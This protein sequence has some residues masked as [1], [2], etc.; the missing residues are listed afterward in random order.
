MRAPAFTAAAIVTLAL[1]IGANTALFTLLDAIALRPL[2]VERPAQLVQLTY[3]IPTG[4]PN[5]AFSYPEFERA[6]QSR[7]FS[8]VF[9]GTTVG[10]V[11]L[12]ARGVA[13][14]A[15]AQA[16]SPNF[17][18]FLGLHVPALEGSVA[19]LSDHY[20]RSRFAADPS[21]VGARVTVNQVPLT[22]IG[23]APPNFNGMY[24]G[25]TADVWI[26]LRA[27]DQLNPDPLR[28]TGPDRAWIHIVGRLRDG[29]TLAA[30]QQELAPLHR[31]N[32]RILLRSVETGAPGA[33]Q[34]TYR[35][36]LQLLLAIAGVVLLA[37]CANIANLQLARV[38]ARRREIAV[39]MALGASRWRIARQLLGESLILAVAGGALAI[40]LARFGAAALADSIDVSPDWRVFAFTAVLSVAAGAVF[41]IAPAWGATR[42][43][44][45]QR[46]RLG[47]ALVVVQVTLSV[48]LVAG[49][50]LFV[51][52]L[53][54]LWRV[55]V[56]YDRDNVLLFSVDTKLAGYPHVRSLDVY[57]QV[58]DR[59]RAVPGVQSAAASMVRPAD[60]YFS[61]VD[62]LNEL[63]GRQQREPIRVGWN[64][65]TPGYFETISTP[66]LKGRDFDDRDREGAPKVAIVS[67]SLAARAFP[68]QDPIGHRVG[69]WTVVGVVRD[70]RYSGP[71]DEASPMLYYPLA[72]NNPAFAF[73]SFELRGAPALDDVR[74]AVQQV[75]PTLP[76][77]RVRTLRAQFEMA[78]ESER[79]VATVSTAFGALA[80]VLSCVGLYGLMAYAVARRT[81][82]IGV[83]MALGARRGHVAGMVLRETLMLTVAGI[84]IGVPI[85]I[86]SA[87]YAA[88]L[89]YGVGPADPVA[90]GVTVA[91]LLAV[92][93]LA[94]YL[95]A[96]RATRIDPMT[97]LRS[98]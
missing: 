17:F 84:A 93:L 16:Y 31:P 82:E 49:A 11:N 59:M 18:S 79:L 25:V 34:R 30:A 91:A 50:G 13:G 60:D 38:A 44:R 61:F 1:G 28:W 21:V 9:G 41:G 54:Q 63:D 19:V 80:L 6:R 20:W 37:A 72:Q 4:G 51:R 12:V 45:F 58:V 3:T 46:N 69:P 95:P 75:D 7:S 78:L 32:S 40:P 14:L 29:V 33:L 90:I 8:D 52:S 56:G 23:V 48:V 15:H 43:Q 55:E 81:G 71:R 92:A 26:P 83:R 27:L 98:E 39:R 36:P 73:A 87:R 65:V 76:I 66:L 53:Q 47:R 89:L 68:G 35:T 97:A 96:R 64:S 42:I 67:A 22:I 74:A 77:F 62:R 94:G 70:G 57:R 86:G 24:V 2:P 10:R 5:A 85:A 88:S